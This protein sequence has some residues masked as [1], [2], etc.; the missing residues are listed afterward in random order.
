MDG[1]LGLLM[2]L[3]AASVTVADD[4]GPAPLVPTIVD[5]QLSAAAA[6]ARMPGCPLS[7]AP[8]PVLPQSVASQSKD[9]P[10]RQLQ[11][12]TRA[13]AS[14][15]RLK[16]KCDG[17]R[18]AC[19]FA[20]PALRGSALTP[21][22]R[23]EKSLQLCEQE[24]CNKSATFGNASGRVAFDMC[25]V[26]HASPWSKHC[27]S[28]V[29]EAMPQCAD[30]ESG[31]LEPVWSTRRCRTHQLPGDV[32]CKGRRCKIGH[33]TARAM[34]A[35]DGER[36]QVCARHRREAYVDVISRRCIFAG[37]DGRAACGRQALFG[38]PASA[39]RQTPGATC[40]RRQ[41]PSRSAAAMSAL[42]PPSSCDLVELAGAE[43]GKAGSQ[44][45][46]ADAVGLLASDA[47]A[48]L[49]AIPPGRRVL[50]GR[51]VAASVCLYLSDSGCV[52]VCV[53]A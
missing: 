8:V 2:C 6:R 13:C 38:Y 17:T 9:P 29:C 30:P 46:Q 32:L 16:K 14:C 10:A 18:A 11:P 49:A 42:P 47:C 27:T 23:Q 34:Y 1:R 22:S 50:C 39:G 53:C 21:R 51:S 24:G 25:S 28:A 41:S 26:L 45:G 33:C 40:G 35:P 44:G 15:V 3:F 43:C 48:A 20:S 5:C 37:A 31:T 7:E 36:A 52:C 4:L 19:A 12:R